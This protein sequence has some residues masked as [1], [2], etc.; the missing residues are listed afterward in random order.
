MSVWYVYLSCF[1][2]WGDINWTVPEKVVVYLS[3][4]C[5]VIIL[6][7]PKSEIFIFPLCIRIFLGLIS[8]WI[9]LCSLRK[10]KA[11]TICAIN[12]F[13]ICSSNYPFALNIKS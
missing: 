2:I 3:L 7:T 8:L 12:L 10:A 6:A 5:L 1:K 9:M 4:L 13:K 11:I